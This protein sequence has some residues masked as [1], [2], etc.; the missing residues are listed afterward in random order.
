MARLVAA[1]IDAVIKWFSWCLKTRYFGPFFFIPLIILIVLIPLLLPF[2][3]VMYAAFEFGSLTSEV[4]ATRK[5]INQTLD[6]LEK[7]LANEKKKM[8]LRKQRQDLAAQ[9]Q[10]LQH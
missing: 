10:N 7:E 1:V 3:A 9:E 4:K 5:K 8:N 2:F 6:K